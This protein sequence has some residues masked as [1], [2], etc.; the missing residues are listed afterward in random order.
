MIFAISKKVQRVILLIC[1]V[2]HLHKSMCSKCFWICQLLKPLQTMLHTHFQWCYNDLDV[3]LFVMLRCYHYCDIFCY[4]DSPNSDGVKWQRAEIRPVSRT[5][6]SH[7]Q[8][9][10][11]QHIKSGPQYWVCN[12]NRHNKLRVNI[13]S[14]FFPWKTTGKQWKRASQMCQWRNEGSR[15]I[16]NSEII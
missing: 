4:R 11:H 10:D 2:L 14:N 6:V 3:M 1:F 12:Q 16:Q 7:S 15:Q 5:L 8:S 9:F 13:K